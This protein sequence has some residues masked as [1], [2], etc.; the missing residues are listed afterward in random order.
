MSR[1][2]MRSGSK[3]SIGLIEKT[4]V[5]IL[6]MGFND[7]D[8]MKFLK[9]PYRMV[10]LEEAYSRYERLGKD[11][12]EISFAVSLNSLRG[13]AHS[14]L[15]GTI[16]LSRINPVARTCSLGYAIMKEHWGKG[17]ATEAVRLA[18]EH[19]FGPCNLREVTATVYGPN[20]ASIRV[21]E[22]NGFRQAVRFTSHVHVEGYGYVDELIYQLHR[23]SAGH[24]CAPR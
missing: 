1:P 11:Q 22:K 3:V 6:Y 10:S 19:A 21:L 5:P 9:H 15:A 17:Y 18:V 7:P 4:D 20:V 2:I 12:S 16:S 23:A 24:V 14:D 8:V 13:R